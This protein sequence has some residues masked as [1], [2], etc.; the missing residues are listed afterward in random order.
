MIGGYQ[1]LNKWLKDRKERYLSLE[2]ITTYLKII[3]SLKYTIDLQKSIDLIYP[4]IE[5]NL[6]YS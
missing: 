3:T 1:V 2:E 4:K 6:I 5:E